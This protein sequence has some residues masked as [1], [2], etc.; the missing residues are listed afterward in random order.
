M[1]EAQGRQ[2]S[3]RVSPKAEKEDESGGKGQTRRPGESQVEES[4]SGGEIEALDTQN[5]EQEFTRSDL[6]AAGCVW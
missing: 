3:S 1:G 2:G 5:S 6:F 4:E